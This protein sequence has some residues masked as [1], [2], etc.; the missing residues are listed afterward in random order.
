MLCMPAMSVEMEKVATSLP[1]SGEVPSC[2]VPSR[3]VTVPVGAAGAP[4]TVEAIVAVKVTLWFKFAD[5]GP[6]RAVVVPS[7]FTT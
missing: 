2:F 7:W 6:F 4:G 1:F 3:N 5:D